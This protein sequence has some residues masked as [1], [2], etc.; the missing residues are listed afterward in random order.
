MHSSK[1]DLWNGNKKISKE[2]INQEAPC[3]IEKKLF[4]F[5]GESYR[6][7]RTDVFKK[8]LLKNEPLPF[9]YCETLCSKNDDTHN[10]LNTKQTFYTLLSLIL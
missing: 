4:L 10:L 1:I 5:L 3:H 9:S 7:I 6:L 8:V 2:V